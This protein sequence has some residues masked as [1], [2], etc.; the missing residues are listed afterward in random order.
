MAGDADQWRRYP[1]R[2]VESASPHY[3]GIGAATFQVQ[4]FQSGSVLARY[5]YEDVDFGNAGF[6]GGASATI[7]FQVDDQL[8][9]QFSQN[10]SVL[11]NGDV[12]DITLGTPAVDVDTFTVDL[13]DSLGQ[14]IDLYL[15]GATTSF[16]MATV[17]LLD[18]TDSVVATGSSSGSFDLA[19]FDAPIDLAGVYTVRVTAGFTGDY[20]VVLTDDL[21]IDS[22]PNNTPA[23]A[24]DLNGMSGALGNISGGA[25]QHT[26]Y[27]D[28]SRF[29]DISANGTVPGLADD[30]EATINT[31]VG[32]A[33]FP[34]GPTTVGNN[35]VVASG[36]G[37]AV[38]TGNSALPSTSFAAAL[39]VFWDDIDADTGNVY[40]SER[41]VNGIDTLI[42]QWDSR[43]HF[44]NIGDATFQV[45]LFAS[46][47]VAAPLCLQRRRF[48]R[49]AVQ[50]RGERDGGRAERS[51]HRSDRRR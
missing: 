7:G 40:W 48:W 27:N 49:S 39:S 10:T 14:R 29:V 46:G 11:S 38:G 4:L 8:Y 47:P 37:V 3:N 33:L 35:G 9:G 30:D 41:Q 21:A 12:V 5:A 42:V 50:L 43:P 13:S 36:A 1:H 44:S 34:A 16:A 2:A 22:E 19:I 15:K 32:N 6:N 25:I 24:R 23:T 18:P 51:I 26:R 28:I 45:Q 17:E 20:Y 31:T